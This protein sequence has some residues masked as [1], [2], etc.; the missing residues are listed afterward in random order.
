M[1]ILGQLRARFEAALAHVDAAALAAMVLPSQDAKFGDYQANCAMPLAKRLG[2]APRDVAAEIVAR[3]DVADMCDPPEIAGPGFINLR[4]RDRWLCRQ[5]AEASN[6]IHRLGIARVAA[7]RTFVIDYSSPNVAKPMHVGHIRSTILGDSL[8][9]L[10]R[11]L[12]HRVITDN[13]IGDWGTQ[14]GMLLVGWKRDLD[15]TALKADAIAELERIYKRISVEY[16]IACAC[17]SGGSAFSSPSFLRKRSRI[18]TVMPCTITD[19]P[20]S[21]TATSSNGGRRGFRNSSRVS[22]TGS[23]PPS[24]PASRRPD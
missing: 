3:L 1:N 22:I 4:L 19:P 10:L 11:L 24:G 16:P 6:D 7:P 18:A 23:C 2:R 9:R 8:A 5:L 13:H 14:F 21:G 15:T 17:C 20:S 12:G